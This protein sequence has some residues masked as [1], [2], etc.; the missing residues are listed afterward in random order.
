MNS[1]IRLLR[2]LFLKQQMLI[3]SLQLEMKLTAQKTKKFTVMEIKHSVSG[4][5][6]KPSKPASQ[7]LTGHTCTTVETKAIR[8]NSSQVGG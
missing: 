3:P 4:P 5:E 2:L 6:E 7:F 8:K 1:A